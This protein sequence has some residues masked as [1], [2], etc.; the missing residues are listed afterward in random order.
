MTR[1]RGAENQSGE[2]HMRGTNLF[3]RGARGLVATAVAAASITTGALVTPSS[4]ARAVGPEALILTGPSDR[5]ADPDV[6]LTFESSVPRAT[7]SIR[8]D[9]GRWSAWHRTP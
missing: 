7:Y 9:R 6:T 5:T 2:L 4:A 3:S 8:L 1:L